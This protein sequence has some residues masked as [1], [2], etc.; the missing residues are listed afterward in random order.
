M[1]TIYKLWVEI[2]LVNHSKNKYENISPDGLPIQIGQFKDLEMATDVVHAMEDIK[3]CRV[4][5]LIKLRSLIEQG[6]K[7]G[8]FDDA[9]VFR[10][11]LKKL[12]KRIRP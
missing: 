6:L 2:E 11:D 4:L 8:I 12:L 9:P 5:E 7:C 3:G 10:K 1:S